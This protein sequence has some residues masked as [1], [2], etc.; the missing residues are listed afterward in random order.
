MTTP[1][2]PEDG[3]DPTRP[4]STADDAG[5]DWW[6][7]DDGR[8]PGSSPDA[9]G[10]DTA[11]GLDTDGLDT[12]GS[13]GADG[14]DARREGPYDAPPRVRSEPPGPVRPPRPDRAVAPMLR[15]SPLAPPA[16][17]FEPPPSLAEPG[18][19]PADEDDLELFGL[20]PEPAVARRASGGPS[21]VPSP[22]MPRSYPQPPPARARR[23]P[24]P[25][26][27]PRSPWL[28]VP[29]LLLLVMAATFLGW[30]S[31]EPL[32]LA[33]GHGQTGTVHVVAAGPQCRGTFQ[34]PVAVS[35]VEIAGL[36]TCAV[37]STHPARMASTH[38]RYAYVDG[39][40][41]LLLRS[42]TGVVAILVCGLILAWV[43]GAFRFAGWRRPVAILA[44]VG[45][46]LG[47]LAGFLA[48]AY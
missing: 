20:E 12:D 19:P 39:D 5:A 44:S 11:V 1:T 4:W 3:A 6:S 30:V 27:N 18:T 43:T 16:D 8:T 26:R 35:S 24:R 48:L 29:G 23:A 9:G 36:A 38:A 31:A 13:D 17:A 10:P 25:P 47:I 7:E 45:A 40:R 42:M 34:A 2:T 33:A 14:P 28:A 21:V 37:G 32:W 46:P 15:R 41:G 22:R